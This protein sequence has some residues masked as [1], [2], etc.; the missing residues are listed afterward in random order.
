MDENVLLKQEILELK[1]Q[2]FLSNKQAL[3][4]AEQQENRKLVPSSSLGTESA[5]KAHRGSLTLPHR[6]QTTGSS[7]IVKNSVDMSRQELFYLNS[8]R[9]SFEPKMVLQ[10]VQQ[11]N[12][13]VLLEDSGVNQT[14]TQGLEETQY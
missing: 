12:S 7:I 3:E 4:R 10:E 11:N 14:H 9:E 5:R 2:L 1:R 13:I 6:N 8:K